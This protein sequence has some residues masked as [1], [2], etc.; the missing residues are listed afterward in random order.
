VSLNSSQSLVTLFLVILLFATLFLL[1]EVDPLQRI[2]IL[3]AAEG[4][5]K[6]EPINGTADLKEALQKIGSMPRNKIMA[7]E[8]LW[9]PQNEKDTLSERE[10]LEDYPLLRP[11]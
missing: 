7:V 11:L 10:L 6:L 1:T 4:I 3:V 9:T 2:T 8:V 5:H